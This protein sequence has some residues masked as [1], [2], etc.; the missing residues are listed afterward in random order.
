MGITMLD[1]VSADILRKNNALVMSHSK[2]EIK[3]YLYLILFENF[4][5][6]M[7]DKAFKEFDAVN[8]AK[9]FDDFIQNI[10]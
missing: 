6:V 7:D 8:V 9:S 10:K 5:I 2:D 3:N 1:G 4:N